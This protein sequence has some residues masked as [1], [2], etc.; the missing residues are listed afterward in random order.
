MSKTHKQKQWVG[1]L[2]S[3]A[4][5][6]IIFFA[7]DV[8]FGHF[9]S[10]VTI[11]LISIG[12]ASTYKINNP[13]IQGARWASFFNLSWVSYARHTYWYVI[14]LDS[15]KRLQKFDQPMEWSKRL[16]RGDTDAI[17][18]VV[19]TSLL[20]LI[21]YGITTRWTEWT[22]RWASV[23]TSLLSASLGLQCI[24]VTAVVYPSPATLIASIFFASVISP[25]LR[26]QVRINHVVFMML[27]P[28]FSL[29]SKEVAFVATLIAGYFFLYFVS[30]ERAFT[31]NL[32]SFSFFNGI[33]FSTLALS[34][35]QDYVI[36]IWSPRPAGYFSIFCYAATLGLSY[37]M[38]FRGDKILEAIRVAQIRMTPKFIRNG[39][40]WS[41]RD[42]WVDQEVHHKTNKLYRIHKPKVDLGLVM[43]GPRWWTPD[44][45]A[46]EKIS[47][48]KVN[49]TPAILSLALYSLW[50]GVD[51]VLKLTNGSLFQTVGGLSISFLLVLGVPIILIRKQIHLKK[52]YFILSKV[53][54][55]FAIL[56]FS[57][58][59][60]SILYSGFT[61]SQAL[62][63]AAQ[64]LD[65]SRP[66]TSR[67]PDSPKDFCTC[68]KTQPI[69]P[70]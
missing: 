46:F 50:F 32:A 35:T 33:V 26:R 59:M 28:M 7:L 51:S 42:L 14:M 47:F 25:I 21:F 10:A 5:E 34:M 49:F 41:A 54:S 11:L 55:G 18:I 24:I 40:W 66:D 69:F 53:A 30:V 44:S 27:V 39:R 65:Q 45:D 9:V 68:K 6:A 22:E 31:K 12:F 60:I 13:Y 63:N 62:A 1:A 8:Y 43:F 57:F 15:F 38:L 29:A 70:A 4:V 36:N 19:T 67:I 23:R 3:I 61:A 2:V 52:E 56:L 20:V 48:P 64:N 17:I 58:Y 37:A 16:C